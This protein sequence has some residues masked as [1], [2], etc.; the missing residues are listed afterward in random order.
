MNIQSQRFSVAGQYVGCVHFGRTRR[1]AKPQAELTDGDDRSQDFEWAE[2]VGTGEKSVQDMR[3]ML[4][5]H[6]PK[7]KIKLEKEELEYH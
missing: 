3:T 6:G 7:A 5:I 2:T 4:E 1:Q